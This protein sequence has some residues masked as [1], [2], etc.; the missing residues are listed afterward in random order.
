MKLLMTQQVTTD[1]P[2]DGDPGPPLKSAAEVME[3]SMVTNTKHLAEVIN[4][5]PDPAKRAKWY[6]EY[7]EQLQELEDKIVGG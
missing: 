4:R 1:G 6:Q 3:E 2:D 7:V 5:L